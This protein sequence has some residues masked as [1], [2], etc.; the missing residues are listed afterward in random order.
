VTRRR[1][2]WFSLLWVA[3]VVVLTLVPLEAAED[4]PSSFCVL[5]RE[6]AVADGLLNAA[7]FLPLGAA[8]SVGGWRSR[9]ALGL[10]WLL[11]LAVE[12]AQLVIPGRDPSP[13][14]LLFN[15]LGTALG[16]VLVRSASTW[17]W[18]GPRVANVLTIAGAI[19]ATSILALSS[20]LFGGFFSKETYYAGWTPRLGHLEW[21]GGR[22]VDVS[23]DGLEIP[24]SVIARSAEVRQRLLAGATL[25][26][27]GHAGPRPPGLAPMFTI[28]D[29]DQREIVLLGADGDDLVYRYRTRASA[30]GLVAPE[31]RV[32]GA[33]RGIAWR[34]PVDIAVRRAPGGHCIRVNAIEHCP[35]GY[36]LGTGWVLL[37]GAQPVTPRLGSVFNV[38]WLAVLFFPT[39]FR[40][41]FRW[42]SVAAFACSLGSLLV[43]PAV[44]RLLP[45]PGVEL[46]G[47]L[48]GFVA[49]WVLRPASAA[50]SC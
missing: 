18:P 36:T 29:R 4:R 26:V 31:I 38:V 47:A 25:R 48:A 34:E 37:L 46:L 11:S 49:G 10:G 33:L 16:I 22:V 3:L 43:L 39:G 1:G 17:W 40:G 41:R 14:D 12:T 5:C 7:L 2:H 50:G 20:V 35:V 21:Y 30:W 45:T 13:S 28:H 44:I 23:L 32:G 27:R 15:T 24:S 19:G 8:L 6:G 9:R 42:S